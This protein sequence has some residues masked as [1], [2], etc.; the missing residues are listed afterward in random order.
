MKIIKELKRRAKA[1]DSTIILPEAN[2]DA[3]VMNA[4]EIIVKRKLSK[5]IVFGKYSD[6]PSLLKNSDL[7]TI[8]DIEKYKDI[9][10]L[11]KRLYQLRKHKGMTLEQAQELIKEPAYL[12]CMMLKY[13]LADGMVAG[14]K[15][16]TANTLRPALQII[17]TKPNK[18]VVTGIM[19]MLKQSKEPRVFADISLNENPTSEELS[20]IAISSA[21]FMQNVVGIEPKVAMLSYSTHGSAKSDMVAKVQNATNLAKLSKFNVDGEMQAD[22]ALNPATAKKKGITS[23]VGGHANVLVF[24]DLN[25]GNIGYKLVSYFGEYRAIGPIMLNFNKPVNDLSRGCTVDEIIDTVCITKILS[26]I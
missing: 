18:S 21:E 26:K 2:L 11:A 16:T 23:V 22:S 17:K 4:C 24:P 13:N 20:E 3:R 12:A 5:I 25:A 1:I 8:I 6:F 7:C 10:T 19:L 15:W 14:A 9:N